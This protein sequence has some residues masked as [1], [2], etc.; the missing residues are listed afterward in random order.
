M[1]DFAK[2]TAIDIVFPWVDG[3]DPAWQAEKAEFSNAPGDKRI[4]RYRDWDNLQ[5]VFRGIEKFLPWVRT[6]HFITW[7]HLPAW[8]NPDCPKLHIV[9]H[10][11]Y[12]PKEY[13]PTYS[14][15]TIELN[16]HRIEGLT[17]N[18]IYMNDDMFFLRSLAPTEYFQDGKPVD[19]AIQN[20]LQFRRRDGIDHIVANDLIC[21]NQNF[22]KRQCI[23]ANR[24]KWFSPAYGV[25]GLQNAYLMPLT[26]FTGFVDY[27]VPYAYSKST[28]IELWDKETDI[29]EKT[30][31]HKFRTS[32]DVNQWLMR[33]WQL[34]KG[35][36]VPAKSNRGKLFAIGAQDVEIED[37]IVHQ[38]Y[39]AICLSDDDP[40]L[41]FEK[42]KCII[43][44]LFQKILPEKS[45][46]ER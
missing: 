5:Y 20:V 23:R 27:H 18:F 31:T 29:L 45:S 1:N 30:C 40:N 28:L 38:K 7:G 25:G 19:T 43:Q 16:M 8:M 46:F 6:V 12:I 24:K 13:L 44:E 41:D 32:E 35:D 37:A 11:D 21:L 39:N 14:A 33:Y 34:A 26:N 17:E 42:E 2:D 3:N 10:K 22:Q 9:N 15:N 36:F 4:I